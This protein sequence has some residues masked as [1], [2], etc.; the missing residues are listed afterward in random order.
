MPFIPHTEEDISAMLASIGANTIDDLFDEIPP[1]LI[2]AGLKQVPPGM[3]EMDVTRLM[4]ERAEADGR[5]LS[6]IG[7]GAYEHHIPAAV[8]QIFKIFSSAHVC[9]TCTFPFIL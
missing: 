6:F 9:R 4:L 8:W 1:S 7:A 3:S 5:Y 2:S